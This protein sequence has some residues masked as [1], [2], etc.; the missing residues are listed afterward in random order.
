MAYRFF[1]SKLVTMGLVGSLAVSG[2]IPI[3]TPGV[4]T[5]T[6]VR[7]GMTAAE[8]E[9]QK[10]SKALQKTVIEG[11]TTGAAAGAALSL[12]SGGDNFWRNV[13]I[14]AAVGALA[15]SYVASLQKNFAD[16]EAQ[17]KQAR[18]D[19]RATISET[20]ATLR[21]MRIVQRREVAEVARLRAALAQGRTD[22]AS[23]SARIRVAKAN[24][25][26]MNGAI[27]GAEN[28]AEE[29][30]QARAMMAQEEGS[31]NI[32]RELAELQNRITQM[33]AVAEDLS[34]NL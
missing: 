25:A 17:L 28:R 4:P 29:F 14:G 33:R 10:R 19:I 18:A 8:A 21:V 34:Q 26:D 27:Q 2:C 23:L 6:T 11:A 22:S 9:L 30:R 32:D 5:V 12:V 7:T 15:G 3:V 31:G 16:R 13:L 1:A 20:D 24:L